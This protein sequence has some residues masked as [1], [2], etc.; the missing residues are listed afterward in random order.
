MQVLN[1]ERCP[2][3]VDH[4]AGLL[5][6]TPL[7]LH[8]CLDTAYRPSCW[9]SQGQNLYAWYIT[10]CVPFVRPAVVSLARFVLSLYPLESW[11][12]FVLPFG[13]LYWQTP[14]PLNP[15]LT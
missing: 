7:F 14:P 4:P 2:G 15:L 6:V 12:V 11:I 3:V 10:P 5:R 8:R 13:R 1:P 9:L